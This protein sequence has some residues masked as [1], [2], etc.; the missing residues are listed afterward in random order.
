MRSPRIVVCGLLFS[1]ALSLSTSAV[2]AAESGSLVVLG[3]SRVEL[4]S[5]FF[6]YTLDVSGGLRA[7]KWE[8]RLTGKTISL[9]RGPELE[10]D[11]GELNGPHQTPKWR[12][13]ALGGRKTGMSVALGC[14]EPKLSATVLYQWDDKEPVLH[15]FVTITNDGQREVRLLNVRLGT[16]P[17]DAKLA[18]RE[19][20]FPVYL[21]GEYFM[22]L[23][24]PAGWA[25]AK[26]KTVS[27][28]QYPGIKLAPGAKFDCMEAVY[29]VGERDAARKTFVAHVRSRMRRVVRGHDKPYAIFDNFGSWPSGAHGSWFNS[30]EFE[31]H[32]LRLLAKSQKATGCRFDFCNIH[33]WVDPAGDLKR[34]NPE[35][36]PKGIANIK[37]ILDSLGTAPGLWIDS[38]NTWGGGWGIGLNPAARPSVSDNPGWFCRASEPIKTLYREGFLYQIRHNGVRE[39]KCDNLHTVCNNPRH[40]HLPGLYST[41]AIENSVIEFLHDLDKECPEA[42]LILY[43]GYRSPWWLL[44]GDTLFDSGIGIEAASPSSQPAIYARDSVTQKLDQAQRHACD[45]PALGKDSL[46]IW[47]S[48]WAWN[49][50]IGKERWQEG[51]VMDISRGSLMAQIWADNDWLSPPEWKQLADF[52]ALLRAEP[53]CFENPHFIL[54]NPLKD[55]PYGYCCTDGRRAFLAMNNCTWQDRSLRLELNLALGLPDGKR[56]D[57]YRRYPEPAR[58]VGDAASFGPQA[59]IMLKPFEVVL[60]EVVPAGQRPSLGRSFVEQP[61]PTAFAEASR[62]I[63]LKV[64]DKNQPSPRDSAIWTVLEPSS[65]V[66]KGG[67]TLTKQ[68]DGSILASGKNPSPDTYVVTAHTKLRGITGIRLEVLDDPQLPS[69]GPGRVFNGNF[70]LSEFRVAAAPRDN[71]TQSEPV[72]LRNASASFSQ[73]SFGGWPIEAAIDGDAKTAWSI[74]P[75]EGDSQTAVFETEKPLDL[76]SGGR[77]TFTLDQGYRDGPADHTIG[78][79]RLSVTTAK[80]PLPRPIAKDAERLAIEAQTP[81]S[82]H[83]GT[84]VVA[85]ELKKGADLAF[86]GDIGTHFSGEAKLARRPLPCQPVLGKGTYPSCW[87]AWR[88]VLPPSGNPQSVELSVSVS[89][90][91]RV[92]CRFHGHF[93]PNK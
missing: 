1:I 85:A 56:W 3:G 38:S 87:Q 62:S 70:A 25:T 2:I 49:S 92:T 8:N 60:V 44:H 81:A 24:H 88:I 63:D 79:F 54:G 73:T 31:L 91:A 42:F 12:A 58:L 51:F 75:R 15:K 59:A 64:H 16:Y 69:G 19:Q 33:F 11:L 45:V 89:L 21:N 40:D 30:D 55:E 84:F 78:R 7:V 34:W 23:A 53:K 80:P 74:D 9:G 17:T 72:R 47:L 71:P 29:G 27:L 4:Q 66:S 68:P 14:T 48:D 32:S 86:F 35:K 67:A 90:P 52:L 83:G 61:I 77:L 22:S 46:G 39:L 6:V 28:R 41:E 5:S 10:V 37:P 18:D 57:L 36:F 93:I 50:S 26:D 13:V 76:A 65:A 20:G 82:A 43:W